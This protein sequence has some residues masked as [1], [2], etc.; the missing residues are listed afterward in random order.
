MTSV[1]IGLNK[2]GE[3]KYGEAALFFLPVLSTLGGE[4]EA[5]EQGASLINWSWK[6]RPTW[7]HTFLTH[8]QGPKVFRSLLGRAG[9]TGVPQGQWL[10]NEAAAAFL[11]EFHPL[12][13][14]TEVDLPEA[15]GQLIH[16]T[17]FTTPASRARLVPSDTGLFS[18]AF[19]IPE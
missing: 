11:R 1:G 2:L 15:L 16:P 9:G 13:G 3:H 6:S 4:G 18:S 19:P 12:S 5:A 14:I 7:G 17:G 10:N 8:G